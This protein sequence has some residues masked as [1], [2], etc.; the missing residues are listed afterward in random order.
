[1]RMNETEW[2]VAERVEDELRADSSA[3]IM[4]VI[5]IWAERYGRENE[6]VGF[7]ERADINKVYGFIAGGE[8]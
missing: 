1:M 2:L 4:E 8:M 3:D 7:S 6:E 5:R